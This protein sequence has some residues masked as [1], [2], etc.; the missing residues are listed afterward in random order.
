MAYTPMILQYLEIKREYEYALVFY[1]LGD[2]Y[3]LFFND[4]LIASKEL[5]IRLTKRDCGGGEKAPMCGVPHHSSEGYVNKLV[6]LGYRVA[7]CEQVSNPNDQK[8]IV[9]REVTRVVSKGTVL[10]ET[11]LVEDKNNYICMVYFNE[12]DLK[13]GISFCDITNGEFMGVCTNSDMSSVFDEIARFSPSEILV[14]EN[15][16]FLKELENKFSLKANVLSNHYFDIE[17]CTQR[18]KRHFEVHNLKGY[19]IDEEFEVVSALGGL[20]L[21]LTMTQKNSLK[22]INSIK[23]IETTDNL[24]IDSSTRRNLELTENMHTRTKKKTLFGTLEKTKTSLGS[25]YLRKSIDNPLYDKK[26]IQDRLDATEYFYE[27]ILFTEELRELL[28]TIKDIERLVG[29]LVFNQVN[30]QDLNALGYSFEY[31]PDIKNLL[32]SD[33][34]LINKIY[35]SFDT[36]D[37][38]HKLIKDVINPE[39]PVKINEGNLIRRGFN[40]ELDKLYEIKENSSNYILNLENTEREKTGIKNLKIKYN[41]ILG[42]FFEVTKSHL[43]LVPDYFIGKQTLVGNSR[44]VTNELKE[45]EETVLTADEKIIKLE[46]EIFSQLKLE[47]FENIDRIKRTALTIGLIDMLQSFAYVSYKNDYVKPSLVDS[48]EIKIV[49]GRHPVV[50]CVK[51]INFTPNDTNLDIDENQLLVITG[52]NMAGKSTY[53]RQVALIVV[54]AQIGCFVPA[55]S[56]VLSPV[57]KLFTR[58]GASDDLAS[59]QSTFML[60]M[61]ELANILNN[62]TKNSLLILD[63]IGRGTST[64]DGLSIAWSVLEHISNKDILG[65]KTL[66]ATHYHELIE[67]EKNIKGIKNYHI[68]IREDGENVVF[69]H[70]IEPGYVGQSYGIHVAKLAGV[71]NDV[72]KRANAILNRLESATEFSSNKKEKSKTYYGNKES[73]KLTLKEQQTFDLVEEIQAIDVNTLSPIVAFETIVNLKNKLDNINEK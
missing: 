66:F 34:Y 28:G 27:N 33:V 12:K 23:L 44:Y 29:R 51:E 38:L 40:Q 10:N 42:Y 68:T 9:K 7:I 2:F 24:K 4:A 16:P 72:I 55:T 47:L 67:L 32:N 70:K 60:E 69:L 17:E 20:L 46:G 22:H 41:K 21:Y 64:Y 73:K 49:N 15:L 35:N 31:L 59:G 19:G 25:R 57:D 65:A 11:S 58:V 8:G 13:I 1:R 54:M 61:N 5:D 63:E 45:I 50:E 36:L 48:G 39:A 43:S 6:E 62:A 56:A 71:P 37:D 18:L 52:P 3:E 53:M 26:Q 30:G 14:C